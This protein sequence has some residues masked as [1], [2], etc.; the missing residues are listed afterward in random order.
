VGR[1]SV[2]SG[3]SVGRSEAHELL[4]RDP[5]RY[6]GRGVL[7]AVE[8]V[9]KQIAP[10]LLGQDATDQAAV[11]RRLI[12]LDGTRLKERLGANA[13]LA[14]SLATAR[15]AAIAHRVPLYRHIRRLTADAAKA[16][17]SEEQT[18]VTSMLTPFKPDLVTPELVLRLPLPLVNMISGGLHPGSSL[19][20]QDFLVM[21][22]G[23]PSYREAVEWCV[24]IY[25]RLGDLL[26]QRSYPRSMVSG[27]GAY[28]PRLASDRDALK[29][30]TAAIE[31]AQLKPL[32]D[33]AIALDAAASRFVREGKY[34][35]GG[36]DAAPST[37]EEL[38]ARYEALCK[39]FPIVSIEDGL[40]DDDWGGWRTLNQKLGRKVWLAGD[41]LFATNSQR[42]WRG[43]SIGVGNSV[44]IKPSQAGTLTE[45]LRSLSVARLAG[46]A[47]IVSGRGADTEDDFIADLAV[48]TGA[49]QIKIGSLARSER[50]AKYNR[51][52]RIEE[53]LSE[54]D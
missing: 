46:Y 31:A 11:D 28:G 25:R 19:D 39:E 47:T 20:V 10:A 4:D 12:E 14:V 8:N 38:I 52:L 16:A 2:P 48:G 23:A 26:E 1:A 53:E 13:I 49:G 43:L 5:R 9:N 35:V 18:A 42:I 24:R 54:R 41:D 3:N 15:A 17:Q 34:H 44:V 32:D 37:A 22:V 33:V 51:L 7:K 29:L 45:T 50:L 21:P 27:D 36:K 6:D 40:G 30:L